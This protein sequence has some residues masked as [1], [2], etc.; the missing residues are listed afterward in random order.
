MKEALSYFH[1]LEK[2]PGV[3]KQIYS[4]PV[5]LTPLISV[6]MLSNQFLAIFLLVFFLAADFATGVL[7]SWMEAKKNKNP[8]WFSSEKTRLS[9]IKSVTYMLFI[10]G[11]WSI[12]KIFLVKKFNFHNFS[13][14]DFSITLLATAICICVEFYS[15]F[16]ENLPKAGFDLP[17]I[18]NKIFSK[19]KDI[20]NSIKSINNDGNN[21]T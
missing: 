8:K 1:F 11:T 3:A 20:K 12:D 21:I 16:W 13:D 4:H 17:G 18:V 5:L 19:V 6:F 10:L 7:A 15:I 2:I 14:A 9:I